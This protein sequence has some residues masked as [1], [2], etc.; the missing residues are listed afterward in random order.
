MRNR[1]LFKQPEYSLFYLQFMEDKPHEG[2]QTW[3]HLSQTQEYKAWSGY[4]FENICLKHIPQ[5]KKALGFASF[6][7]QPIP[8]NILC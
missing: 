3:Q 7:K 2:N 6:R 8:E 4:A 1:S 5:I